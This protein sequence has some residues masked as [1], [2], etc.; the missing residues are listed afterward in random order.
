MEKKIVLSSHLALRFYTINGWSEEIVKQF[1]IKGTLKYWPDDPDPYWVGEV[2]SV[3]DV[4]NLAA[5]ARIFN[6]KNVELFGEDAK[7]Y[8]ETLNW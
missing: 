4:E 6:Y 1:M 7:G 8:I 5:S 3:F 2:G